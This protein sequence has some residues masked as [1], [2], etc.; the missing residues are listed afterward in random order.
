MLFL[1]RALGTQVAAAEMLLRRLAAKV[2]ENVP[3][4]QVLAQADRGVFHPERRQHLVLQQ[5]R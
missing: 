1:E 5:P 4:G 2:R 3:L